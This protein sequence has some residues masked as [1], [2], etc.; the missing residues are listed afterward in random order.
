MINQIF[1]AEF[2]FNSTKGQVDGDDSKVSV[3]LLSSRE[4]HV[5]YPNKEPVQLLVTVYNAIADE[6]SIL[7]NKGLNITNEHLCSTIRKLDIYRDLYQ[8]IRRS[9]WIPDEWVFFSN[10]FQVRRQMLLPFPREHQK[11]R[12]LSHHALH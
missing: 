1:R 2:I 7:I 5:K 9:Q 4:Q 6:G 10:R 11:F 3:V 8:K 12:P